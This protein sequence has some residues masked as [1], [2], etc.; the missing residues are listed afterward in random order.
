MN[1][2]CQKLLAQ[3]TL[4]GGALLLGA[5][6]AAQAQTVPAQ[7]LRIVGGLAGVNQYT[8]N[9]EP[10]WTKELSRLTGGKF[11]AEIVPFD[12]AGVPGPNMLRL[13]EMGVIPFGT[14]L[15][16][17]LPA[18]HADLY[19]A[20]LAGLNPDMASLRKSVAAFR[21]FLEQHL[22]E[23]GIETLA[24]Y[25]YPAQVLFCRKPITRLSEL[26]GRRIRVSSATQAD[27]IGALRGIPVLTAFAEIMANITSGNVDCAVTGTMSGNTLGLHEVTSYLYTMPINWGM[28][29]FGANV[30]AWAA[31]PPDLKALLRGELP[32]LEAAIWAES[33]RETAE[34]VACNRGMSSCSKGRKGHMTEAPLVAADERLRQD[35]LRNTVLPRWIE[36]CGR[37][38]AEVWNQT[39]GKASDMLATVPP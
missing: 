38:C 20:D 37:R 17:Q 9:E 28:A 34:G 26:S 24:I 12:R 13:M 16:S 5:T 8:H 36:R 2:Y 39:L 31:L 22:R 14:A 15:V 19:A 21:P 33:E 32:K 1:T 7:T 23:H 6:L 10:F 18:Q 27:F 4:F 25:I 30:N 3:V 29:V 11:N 35:I